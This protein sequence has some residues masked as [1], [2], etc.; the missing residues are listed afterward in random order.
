MFFRG[1]FCIPFPDLSR[2]LR[3]AGDLN[4]ELEE[5]RYVVRQVRQ[6]LEALQRA[7]VSDFPRTSFR[8]NR[9]HAGN[10]GRLLSS[11][12]ALRRI[13]HGAR[14]RDHAVV[15]LHREL[16]RCQP[17]ILTELA[18]NFTGHLGVVQLP[19]AAHAKQQN[20][21]KNTRIP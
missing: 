8:G 1:S 11:G 9:F 16:L 2:F 19:G 17:G 21:A 7:G 18:L 13:L 5:R 4:D 14:E 10:G 15:G 3:V 20:H 12:I 6:R